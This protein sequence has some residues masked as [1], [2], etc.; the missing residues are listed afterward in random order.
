MK[1]IPA[2]FS[3]VILG[4]SVIPAAAAPFSFNKASAEEMIA[5]CKEEGIVL[6]QDVANAIVEARKNMT[7]SYEQDLMKVPGMTNQLL[8]NLSP[9]EENGD[10]IFDMESIPAMK[11]Y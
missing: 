7:F 5:A 3:L 8:G 10:L 6:P 4:I 2:F 11:G 1:L 9:I